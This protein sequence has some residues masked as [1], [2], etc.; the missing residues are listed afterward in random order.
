MPPLVESSPAYDKSIER[1]IYDTAA[2][3]SVVIV[4]HGASM[5]LAGMPSLPRVP[6]TASPGHSRSEARRPGRHGRN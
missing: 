5:A 1:V 2:A 6:V 3:G 4:A